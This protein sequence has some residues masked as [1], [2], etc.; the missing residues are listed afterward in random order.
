MEEAYVALCAPLR[1]LQDEHVSLR[2]NMERFNEIT[3]DLE[4]ESGSDAVALFA[5]LHGQVAAF[6]QALEV[7]SRREEQGLF[8]L[9]ARRLGEEDRTIET[10]EFEHDKAEQHLRDFLAE[11]GQAGAAVTE[12]DAQSIAVYA[13]QAYATLTQHFAKEEKML[14]PLA[15]RLLSAEEKGELDRLLRAL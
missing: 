5:A 3:E 2:A 6:A 9:M 13:V 4:C 14:F 15:E 1:Q 10:M 8:P 7:H 11:A 12:D